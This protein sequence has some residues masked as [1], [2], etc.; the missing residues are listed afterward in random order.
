MPL[1]IR[2]VLKAQ[3][4]LETKLQWLQATV[5]WFLFFNRDHKIRLIILH[6]HSE[7]NFKQVFQNMGRVAEASWWEVD[8]LPVWPVWM[9]IFSL[10]LYKFPQFYSLV[11]VLPSCGRYVLTSFPAPQLSCVT[12]VKSGYWDRSGFL[13]DLGGSVIFE[14]A[15]V[16]EEPDK[17]SSVS[18]LGK[19]HFSMGWGHASWVGDSWPLGQRLWAEWHFLSAPRI[20]HPVWQ[21]CP[22]P[23]LGHCI[24]TPQAVCFVF[25]CKHCS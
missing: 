18:S 20:W 9:F 25:A 21:V 2:T 13:G 12:R 22:M 10:I 15:K 16:G 7:D 11:G 8:A 5:V 23:A 24:T 19:E 14:I 17:G 1:W 3:Q 4:R 6:A